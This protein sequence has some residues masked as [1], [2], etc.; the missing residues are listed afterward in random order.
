MFLFVFYLKA[1][2]KKKDVRNAA[3]NSGNNTEIFP[4]QTLLEMINQT[5]WKSSK[6][7]E[8]LK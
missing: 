1:F 3:I 2:A 4:K 8:L 6:I 7:K 5:W